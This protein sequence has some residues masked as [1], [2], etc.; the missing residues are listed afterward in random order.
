M[1]EDCFQVFKKLQWHINNSLFKWSS[2]EIIST[3]MNEI[4]VASNLNEFKEYNVKEIYKEKLLYI[5][6]DNNQDIV[7]LKKLIEKVAYDLVKK[8]NE[9]YE[10][11]DQQ[12]FKTIKINNK[13]KNYL[14]K[15]G[16]VFP[17]HEWIFIRWW[18]ARIA[19]MKLMSKKI[20]D[21]DRLT[22]K[23]VD[24]LVTHW[25]YD[26]NFIKDHYK[27]DSNGISY[28]VWENTIGSLFGKTDLTMNQC[29][30]SQN[31]F[32]FTTW[33]EDFVTTWLIKIIPKGVDLYNIHNYNF[34]GISIHSSSSLE[35]VIKFLAEEK[36]KGVL[37]ESYYLNKS[38][39]DILWFDR[40]LIVLVRRVC[41]NKY[42]TID[43]KIQILY[44]LSS[45][46]KNLGFLSS[47]SDIVGLIQNIE[48]SLWRSWKWGEKTVEFDLRRK[49]TK[50]N[51]LLIYNI[52]WLEEYTKHKIKW[53]TTE[54]K[55]IVNYCPADQFK[56]FT[57]D[58]KSKIN[59]AY[60]L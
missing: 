44:N 60:R 43:R 20:S 54:D 32:Y 50:L 33:F 6:K 2:R 56:P 38:N 24:L 52:I 21:Y 41:S 51:N 37:I 13:T 25:E 8:L 55:N 14:K 22:L 3:I 45:I 18:N 29:L 31:E 7:Y 58:F 26:H 9:S 27:A 17:E 59:E 47:E 57:S 49:S 23:D 10:I 42:F 1:T 46:L 36:C 11:D 19:G 28:V 40:E 39:L 5:L 35:R 48:K 53:F 30:L 34:N 15:M 4:S 12:K 16:I